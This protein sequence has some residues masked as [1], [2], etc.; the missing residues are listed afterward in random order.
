[1]HKSYL[2]NPS[3]VTEKK[4]VGLW[5][6]SKCPF[7]QSLNFCTNTLH[8]TKKY[9]CVQRSQSQTQKNYWAR[10]CLLVASIPA[11]NYRCACRIWSCGT[12]WRTRP[13]RCQPMMVGLLS[14]LWLLPRE[15]LP[16]R[17][18]TSWLCCGWLLTFAGEIQTGGVTK[19]WINASYC[20]ISLVG[21]LLLNRNRGWVY[22][23]TTV[24]CIAV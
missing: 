11:H 19:W 1:M 17:A 10:C 13:W 23:C 14:W 6:W 15:W 5:W 18:M 3:H 2:F 12:R 22:L 9:I 8:Q 16:Q 24:Q 20:P 4:W 21:Y 7:N